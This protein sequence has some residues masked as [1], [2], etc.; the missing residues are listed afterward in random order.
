[1]T[2]T[3]I[4]LVHLRRPGRDAGESRNDPFW[5]FGSFGCTRCHSKNLMHPRRIDELEGAR[6][7][8]AQGGHDGFRLVHLTPPVRVLRHQDRCEA[9]WEPVAWPFTYAAAPLLVHNDGRTD[10]PLL[11]RMI[12]DI[13]RDSW[14]ARF[15]SAFRTRRSPLPR[16]VGLQIAATFDARRR[17]AKPEAIA[18]EYWHALPWAPPS[19]NRQRSQ[20][21]RALQRVA[22]ADSCGRAHACRQGPAPPTY[23]GLAKRTRDRAHASRAGEFTFERAEQ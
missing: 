10:F 22:G 7:G 3:P 6:L 12:H 21:Y 23:L 17:R 11:A 16:A 1:M 5:E 13:G 18:T 19:I 15:S 20:T 2:A 4:I 14:E 8:F 9:L